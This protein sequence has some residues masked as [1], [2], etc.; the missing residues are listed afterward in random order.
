MTQQTVDAVRFA[1]RRYPYLSIVYSYNIKYPYLRYFMYIIYNISLNKGIFDTLWN[2]YLYLRVFGTW[3][4]CM[5]F[6][7]NCLS[8]WSLIFFGLVSP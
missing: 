4:I 7:K 2:E 8:L 1:P 3:V 5:G 6:P